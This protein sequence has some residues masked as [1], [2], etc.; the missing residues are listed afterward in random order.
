MSLT[1]ISP[2]S[3]WAEKHRPQRLEDLALPATLIRQLIAIRDSALTL[4]LVF[5][6]PPGTGKTSAAKAMGPDNVYF[7][8]CSLNSGV[9]DIE[10]LERTCSARS[11]MS[12]PR[13][14][15]MDEADQLT[16][17]AQDALRGTIEKLSVANLFVFTVNDITKLSPALRSRLQA[18]DFSHVYG[19]TEVARQMHARAQAILAAEGRQIESEIVTRI[20]K[21][22]FPD[23]RRVLNRLQTETLT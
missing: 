16:R 19:N 2:N 9:S 20:V 18:F 22:C 11:L 5:Y 1:S 8:N 7:I 21:E 13:I 23:M 14:V 15:V 12:G 6:G 3:H 4:P 10:R 17:K